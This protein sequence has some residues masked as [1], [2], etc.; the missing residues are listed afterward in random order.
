MSFFSTKLCPFFSLRYAGIDV[1]LDD[2]CADLASRLDLLA[3]FAEA[4][5]YNCF[6][7]IWV[8]DDLLGGKGGWVVKLLIVGPVGSSTCSVSRRI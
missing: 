6:G 8:G 5:C 3:S 2:C 1:L 4:I 7:A